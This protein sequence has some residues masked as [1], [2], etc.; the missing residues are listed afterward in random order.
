[1]T[2][3]KLQGEGNC[4]AARESDEKST[5]FAKDK[6]RFEK[7]AQVAKQ[8]IDSPEGVELAASVKTGTGHARC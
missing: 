2:S 4:D 6:A 1:M 7:A 8:A 3:N 5:N